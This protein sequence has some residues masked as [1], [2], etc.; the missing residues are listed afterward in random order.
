MTQVDDDA[1]DRLL[2]LYCRFVGVGYLTY[3]GL[4]LHQI[5]AEAPVT[6]AWWVWLAVAMIFVPG[7][8][9]GAMTFRRTWR[10]PTRYAAQ[11]AA[12]GFLVP[13]L[14]WLSAWNGQVPPMTYLWISAIP[15]LAGW[16]A[17]AFWSARVALA[18]TCLLVVLT[19]SLNHLSGAA[20]SYLVSDLITNLSYC[21]LLVGAGC[22]TVRT[23][24]TLHETR[25]R[26]AQDA[27]IAA[28][29]SAQITERR[30]FIDLVHTWVMATL[31]AAARQ[32][33]SES[34]LRRHA[35]AASA[36]LEVLAAQPPSS[37]PVP[38][39]EVA[40]RLSLAVYDVDVGTALWIDRNGRSA[41]PAAVVDAFVAALTEAVR[42][43]VRHADGCA[44]VRIELGDGSACVRISDKGPGFGQNQVD[45]KRLGVTAMKDRIEELPGG[46]VSIRTGV[47]RGTTVTLRWRAPRVEP[48]GIRTLLGMRQPAAWIATFG[49]LLGMASQAVT[50]RS[51]I[52][53][54]WPVGVALLLFV[55]AALALLFV[56]DDPMP[57]L[58][59]I[60]VTL[61]GPVA[62]VLVCAV[63]PVPVHSGTQ[64]WPLFLATTVYAFL[65]VRGRVALGWVGSAL[66]A[67][68]AIGWSIR[69]GQGLVYGVEITAIDI[70]PMTIATVVAR[71]IRPAAYDI[72]AV[73]DES[74][75]RATRSAQL[76]AAT[77]QRGTQLRTLDPQI[78][79]LL[80]TIAAEGRLDEQD[81]TTAGLFEV[82]LR[83]V[84]RAPGLVH[85]LVVAAAWAA[86]RRDVD[87]R[88]VDDGADRIDELTESERENFL[89]W[90]AAEIDSCDR[91]TTIT[92]RVNP[93]RRPAVATVVATTTEHTRRLSYE[94]PNGEQCK[95]KPRK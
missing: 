1:G 44:A 18:Y 65:C 46:S 59:A 66:I 22:I 43:S 19:Q 73:R 29:K 85:P 8:A 21:V 50:G 27:A 42:N 81:T 64:L 35:R 7:I 13:T 94:T 54:W 55:A 70:A 24:R 36:R 52:T 41:F 37:G 47:G 80:A 53:P 76:A 79:R 92:I 45:D 10:A 58:A 78:F 31:L 49:F 83:S 11:T 30:L 74:I 23:G 5:V 20:T 38:I 15:G 28:A 39:A 69:T 48:D 60:A 84:A 71:T 93:P 51:G 32:T 77:A 63:L 88:L 89:L 91:G 95:G 82:H 67:A 62:M 14:L 34:D 40:D 90:V 68:V 16:C 33:L 6:S 72:F 26:A 75:R 2:R 56:P 57:L 12:V 3:F 9:T 25:R 4:V 86:R 61:T 17:A 87:V